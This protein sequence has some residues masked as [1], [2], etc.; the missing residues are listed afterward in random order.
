MKRFLQVCAFFTALFL[1]ALIIAQFLP[2]GVDWQRTF[3]P[4][5][6]ALLQGKSPYLSSSTLSPFANP[7]WLLI[8]FIPL[9]ILPPSIGYA[10]FF[11]FSILGF[12][13][14]AIRMGADKIT[15]IAVLFSPPVLHSLLNANVDWI[16][17]LGFT[18]PPQIG[19][20]LL[21][22]KPQMGLIVVLWWL[23]QTWQ[24]GGI[25]QVVYV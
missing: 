21:L 8:L 7:P 4:A 13:W 10:L 17:L 5:T 25:K 23:I 19:I 24:N 6:L 3:R 2:Q 11:L 12:A 20:F 15:L 22:I 18:L 1:I 9:V 14:A 16:P